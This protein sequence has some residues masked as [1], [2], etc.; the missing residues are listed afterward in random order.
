MQQKSPPRGY[1]AARSLNLRQSAA[2]SLTN[3][4]ENCQIAPAIGAI[5]RQTEIAKEAIASA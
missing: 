5:S 4:A 2:K 1:Y 3:W